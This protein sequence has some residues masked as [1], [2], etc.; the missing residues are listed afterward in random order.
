MAILFSI[1]AVIFDIKFHIVPE[2]LTYGLLIF[3][4]VSNL[5]LSLITSNIKFILASIISMV[6]T[7]VITYMLWK[8][9]M[10]GGGDVILF[11]AI[12]T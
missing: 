1:L 4:L 10:W 8:L 3:G 11:T 6:I 12:A 2:K 9:K 7:Y 5:I